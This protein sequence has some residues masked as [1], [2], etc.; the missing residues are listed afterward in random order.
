MT[1]HTI[2]RKNLMIKVFVYWNLHKNCWSIRDE[3]TK[4]VI[5]HRNEATLYDVTFKVSQA[6]RQRVLREGRKNVHAGAIG[7]LLNEAN[8]IPS[9]EI[10]HTKVTYNPYK[11]DSFI[12]AGTKEPVSKAVFCKLGF[13]KEVFIW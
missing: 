6:G 11:Y 9:P 8:L 1:C 7:Y 3:K 12:N 4:R 13:N 5:H 2:Y 10:Y